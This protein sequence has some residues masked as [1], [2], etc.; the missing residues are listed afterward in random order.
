LKER[1][2]NTRDDSK[3][4]NGS[5]IS[6][7]IYLVQQEMR[8]VKELNEIAD[9]LM[10]TKDFTSYEAFLAIDVE[11]YKYIDYVSLSDFLGRYGNSIPADE[12]KSII[13]RL[14][15]DN[16]QKIS[17]DEFQQIFFSINSTK[18]DYKSDNRQDFNKEYKNE[19]DNI[20]ENNFTGSGRNFVQSSYNFNRTQDDLSQFDSQTK[21][22]GFSN[23]NQRS[24]RPEVSTGTSFY[25]PRKLTSSNSPTRE[26]LQ[27]DYSMSPRQPLREYLS[28]ARRYFSPQRERPKLAEKTL[29]SP[30]RVNLSKSP[31]RQ[32]YISPNRSYRSPIVER[33]SSPMRNQEFLQNEPNNH[34]KNKTNS[35]LLAKYFYEILS[36]DVN[37]ESLKEALSVKSDINIRDLFNYFDLTARSYI[38]LVDMREVLKELD[39][40]AGLDDIKLLYK[41]FDKDLDGRFE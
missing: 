33:T 1:A 11:N 5:I 18:G 39:I 28:S 7:F 9:Q 4:L 21:G 2:L 27:Y 8:L 16:D 6:G 20:S 13:Y 30:Y 34:L 41:R 35:A 26:P 29:Y 25:R 23:V 36:M 17:Y 22:T 37:A 19:E 15:M 24:P 32:R 14:D 31:E 10:N 38:S 40:I 12:A 3:E